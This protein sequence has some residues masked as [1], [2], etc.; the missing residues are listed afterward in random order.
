MSSRPID[1]ELC[2]VTG[3]AGFLGR[4]LVQALLD[5]DCIVH[6]VD[7][8]G[9]SFEDE[10][11]RW[12]QID[13]RDE[14]ALAK[15]CEGIDTIFH[16]AALIETF[17]F[18]PK[19]LVQ[20]VRG[21]NVE[22]TR[23]LLR[24]ASTA[25]VK[26][27]VHTSSIITAWGQDTHGAD[28]TTP[29]S[30]GQDLYS[31]TKVESERLVLR[32]NGPEGM[33]TCALRPGGIYGP[34]ERNL[35][36]GPM[37]EAIKQG[38]PVITFGDGTSRIDY[39]YIDNLVDAQIRAAER[40][41]PGSP[42]CGEAYFVTDGQPINTGDFSLKLVENMGL[43]V[44]QLRVPSRVARTMAAVGERVFR[45]FGR[46]KPVLSIMTVRMCEVDNYFSIT[47]AKRDLG[48]EPIVDTHEGLRR[49]AVE[50]RQYYDSL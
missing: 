47:K 33:L 30:T 43:D 28:E 18:A 16:T 44:R 26:R 14:S 21:V 1:G 48:Y 27:V 35:M 12:F 37:V 2:L 46:P 42:V 50:A 9:P 40:L 29:Y 6:G 32:A 8:A 38:V 7:R 45:I 31:S 23:A 11:L 24:A 3:S 36:V 10:N 15:A 22:G 19:R 25:G 39:T 13:I 41:V 17:T 34:G 5:R 4:N 20:L 49:T